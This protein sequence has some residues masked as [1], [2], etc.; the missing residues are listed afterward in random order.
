MNIRVAQDFT[1]IIDR[2]FI[3]RPWSADNQRFQLT[4]KFKSAMGYTDQFKTVFPIEVSP[5]LEKLPDIT[6]QGS[7]HCLVKVKYPYVKTVELTND[8]DYPGQP[9]L[10]VKRYLYDPITQSCKLFRFS[11][12]RG[13][14]GSDY[15]VLPVGLKDEEN[16]VLDPVAHILISAL[17]LFQDQTYPEH[18]FYKY[19]QINEVYQHLKKSFSDVFKLTYDFE[20]V[21]EDMKFFCDTLT[22]EVETFQRE[23]ANLT[24]TQLQSVPQQMVHH[25]D[26]F[27]ERLC[28]YIP[29]FENYSQKLGK[30]KKIDFGLEGKIGRWRPLYTLNPDPQFSFIDRSPCRS[31]NVPRSYFTPDIA[32]RMN[33]TH[34]QDLI[35]GGGALLNIW[36]NLPF[37]DGHIVYRIHPETHTMQLH[38]KY[39]YNRFASFYIPHNCST[40][41]M[42]IGME[43]CEEF[44]R[45]YE[46]Q[47]G[48]PREITEV[49]FVWNYDDEGLILVEVPAFKDTCGDQTVSIY[50]DFNSLALLVPICAV[51]TT[52]FARK[53]NSPEMNVEPPVPRLYG[54][55]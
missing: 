23:C 18:Y 4:V 29:S 8:S 42:Y 25:F 50:V 14:G 31:L 16:E 44:M 40:P 47:I 27:M 49:E 48:D 17:L 11:H 35:Y 46:R 12:L 10:I 20:N 21:L 13:I 34:F 36:E 9:L 32:A 6:L 55:G 5:Y 7:N 51:D 52:P 19:K 30:W 28:A 22:T 15:Y 26:I 33:A 53:Y 1:S 54:Y 24:P 38:V 37:T 45:F 41:E 39:A 2:R 43:L 3:Y